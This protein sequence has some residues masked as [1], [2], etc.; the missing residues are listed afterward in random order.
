MFLCHFGHLLFFQ[1]MRFDNIRCMYAK[2]NVKDFCLFHHSLKLPH[3]IV[4]FLGPERILHRRRLESGQF[5]ADK[6]FLF[7]FYGRTVTLEK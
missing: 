4:L 1:P 6:F 3:G 5:L 7:P 2:E